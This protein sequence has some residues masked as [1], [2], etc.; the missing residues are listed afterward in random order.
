MNRIIMSVASAEAKSPLDELIIL[1]KC[2][3]YN[4]SKV[5]SEMI[6]HKMG[7]IAKSSI[8]NELGISSSNT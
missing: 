8:A 2:Y 5:R 1:V 3:H 4:A 7:S 6:D